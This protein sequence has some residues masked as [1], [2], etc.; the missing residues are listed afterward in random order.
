MLC[1]AQ[2]V[3]MVLIFV[4]F[5]LLCFANIIVVMMCYFS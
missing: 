3:A 4:F 5:S 2:N 1:M